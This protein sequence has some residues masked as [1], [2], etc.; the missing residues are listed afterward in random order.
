[1]LRQ[2]QAR[3]HARR[4]GETSREHARTD[5]VAKFFNDEKGFGFITQDGG[6]YDIFA[7]RNA[8]NGKVP[9]ERDEES[10]NPYTTN[11]GFHSYMMQND[12]PCS[13]HALVT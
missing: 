11:V 2:Q 1:M 8:V 7:H 10:E 4:D 13:V 5:G 3:E 9:M 12:E 6:D